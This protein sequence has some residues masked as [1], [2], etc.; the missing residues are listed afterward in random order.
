MAKSSKNNKALILGND[1][2]GPKLNRMAFEIYEAN[3]GNKNLVLI[4]LGDDGGF[5]GRKLRTKIEEISD[6]NLTY[7]EARKDLDGKTVL[8]GDE[9]L[10]KELKNNPVV[11]VDDVLYSGKTMFNAIAAVAEHNPKSIQNAV[12]IDRGHR[13]IPVRPDFVGLVL[14]TTLK[15]HVE[16]EIDLKKDLIDAFLV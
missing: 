7:F 2:I 1:E 8:L 5:V 3:F 13:N 4:G 15:Q 11:I 10:G 12:L 16:V 6:F 14:A 9:K